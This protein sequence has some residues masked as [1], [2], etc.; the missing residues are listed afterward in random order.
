VTIQY[1]PPVTHLIVVV[2]HVVRSLHVVVDV[3]LSGAAKRL[4]GKEF[5]FLHARRFSTLHNRHRLSGVDAIRRDGMTVEVPNALHLRKNNWT[6]DR[7]EY[8]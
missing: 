6:K 4:D 2:L 5:S 3:T 7:V 8:K 1:L